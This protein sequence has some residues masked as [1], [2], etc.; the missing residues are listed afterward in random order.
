MRYCHQLCPEM[1]AE[2]K[3]SRRG[4]SLIFAAVMATV[5]HSLGDNS[6]ASR[7]NFWRLRHSRL[8]GY[9]LEETALRK[10]VATA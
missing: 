1:Q 3:I 8:D 2:S 6:E 5:V 10:R 4:Y 7:K 9:T